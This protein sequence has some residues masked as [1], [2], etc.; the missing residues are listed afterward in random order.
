MTHSQIAT[1][2]EDYEKEQFEQIAKSLGLTGAD[3]LRVFIKRFSYEGGFPFDVKINSKCKI[4]VVEL[5]EANG[6]SICPKELDDQG[7]DDFAELAK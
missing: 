2:V 5:P 6:H 3:V 7:D 4:P 1:R